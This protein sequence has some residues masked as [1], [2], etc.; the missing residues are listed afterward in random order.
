VNLQFIGLCTWFLFWKIVYFS[1]IYVFPKFTNSRIDSFVDVTVHSICFA[2]GQAH[3]DEMAI[4]ILHSLPLSIHIQ[5]QNEWWKLRI[6]WIKIC[7]TFFLLE[8]GIVFIRLIMFS[9]IVR[10][11]LIPLSIIHLI[12]TFWKYKYHNSCSRMK[13]EYRHKEKEWNTRIKKNEDLYWLGFL[14]FYM[15]ILSC[16]QDKQINIEHKLTHLH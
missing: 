1:S 12:S 4:E 3:L 13:Q 2:G 15:Y 16:F 14:L 7:N 6:K 11:V 10:R 9:T 5:M 8:L